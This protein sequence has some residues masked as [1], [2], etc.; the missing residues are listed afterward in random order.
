MLQQAA[1]LY[2][3]HLSHVRAQMKKVGSSNTTNSG[4]GSAHAAVG[5]VPMKRLG[6]GGAGGW[7]TLEW[8]DVCL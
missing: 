6:S 7:Y 5:G 4:S 2:E 8:Q 3:R 1:W